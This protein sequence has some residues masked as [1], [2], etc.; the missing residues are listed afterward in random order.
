MEN[1]QS[2]Q[3]NTELPP[4]SNPEQKE[5]S[6]TLESFASEIETIKESIQKRKS[7]TTTLKILFYTG[8]AV[9]LFGFIYTNQTLQRA[10]YKT[11][12]SNIDRLQNQVSH[13]LLLLERKLQKEI[14]D[15]D[16]KL[17]EQSGTGFYNA[18]HN[19]NRM[20]DQIEPQTTSMGILIE[21]IQRNSN[22]LS[23]RVRALQNQDEMPPTP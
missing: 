15:L 20:L 17:Y 12:E 23:Q 4:A 3:P 11:I 1:E 9:L 21:K 19:M 7:E 10:Q 8:L 2:K 13:T 5:N 14:H 16:V 18:I 6:P 22:E